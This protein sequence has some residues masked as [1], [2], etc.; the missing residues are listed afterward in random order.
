MQKQI[1]QVKKHCTY[2]GPSV[3]MIGFKPSFFRFLFRV[4][5]FELDAAA[6]CA[7]ASFACCVPFIFANVKIV[8]IVEIEV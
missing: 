7:A 3:V 6:L 4:V 1:E 2:P 8:E 5:P